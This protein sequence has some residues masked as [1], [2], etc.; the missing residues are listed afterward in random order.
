LSHRAIPAPFAL[1][2]LL[3]ACRVT[4]PEPKPVVL[5]QTRNGD[6]QETYT[7]LS[8]STLQVESRKMIE[9]AWLGIDPRAP[10]PEPLRKKKLP[11]YQGV[12]I[13]SV[14][15]GSPADRSGLRVGDIILVFDGE[16]IMVADQ[17]RDLV[18]KS[19]LDRPVPLTILRDGEELDLQAH[20]ELRKELEPRVSISRLRCKVEHLRSGLEVCSLEP[21]DARTVFG[22]ERPG[23]LV[24]EVVPGGPAYLS[25]LRPGDLVTAINGEP[26]KTH[27]ALASRLEQ[28]QAGDQVTL[29]VRKGS[30]S[31]QAKLSLARR[32]GKLGS[33]T[34]PLLVDYDNYTEYSEFDLL[35]G[36]GF[37]YSSHYL[38]TQRRQSE[39]N[40]KV[41]FLF[42]LIQVK[43]SP[44]RTRIR[45]LWLIPIEW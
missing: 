14:T 25:G 42:D 3:A 29:D 11:T 36:L 17:F 33:F 2:V 26:I 16:K 37:N 9:R 39:G 38:H 21:E 10:D 6:E 13:H 31:F 44:N 30:E 34:I 35:L 1:T 8:S 19:P 27:E 4:P 18:A 43:T 32:I 40:T 20:L 28:G 22:Q 15:A 45:L 24:S 23:A 5:H 12:Q 7:L 41:G